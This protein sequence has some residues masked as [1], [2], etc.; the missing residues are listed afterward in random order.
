MKSRKTEKSIDVRS[1]NYGIVHKDGKL[2]YNG[3]HGGLCVLSLDD[4]S[5]TQLV[6]TT[7]SQYSS[8]AIWSD[9]LYF[10]NKDNSVTCCDLK[11]AVK[12]KLEQK[13]FLTNARGITV[14]DDEGRVY[15]SSY[16]SNNIVVISPDGNKHRVM[17]SVN[18]GLIGPQ[19]LFFDRKKSKLLIANQYDDAFLYDVSK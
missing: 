10:I 2:F 13:T 18:D 16:V 4:D 1:E 7:L 11:G 12:W 6:N 9:N 5:I 17:L 8:I 19:T 3:Y 15:V 14:M